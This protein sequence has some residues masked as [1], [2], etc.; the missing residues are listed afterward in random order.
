MVTSTWPKP[1]RV[2]AGEPIRKPLV[3]NGG[4]I[5]SV[6]GTGAVLPVA[7]ER[8]YAAADMIQ[9]D[10]MQLRRDI[11]LSLVSHPA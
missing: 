4:R 9:C 6:V 2:T 5:L 7:V 3:T 11:A 1:R 10:G 8:A